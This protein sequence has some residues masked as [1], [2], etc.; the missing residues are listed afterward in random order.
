MFFE[1]GWCYNCGGGNHKF[2]KCDS[3]GC[4]KC[5]QRHHTSLCNLVKE[6]AGGSSMGPQQQQQAVHPNAPALWTVV[7]QP[8]PQI[9][10]HS[11]A[12]T[13]EPSSNSGASKFLLQTADETIH[14]TV[15]GVING[16]PVRMLIDTAAG[17]NY[18]S[19][20]IANHL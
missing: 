11:D 6:S 8:T 1:K 20:S 18:I 16:E 14:P 13:F 4:A 17:S 19:L 9:A 3:C 2:F 5:G 10:L 12:P 7:P 15:V